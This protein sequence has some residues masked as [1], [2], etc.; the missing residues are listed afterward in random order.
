MFNQ[1]RTKEGHCLPLYLGFS[2]PTSVCVDNYKSEV[3]YDPILQITEMDMRV[4][5][6]RSLKT[7]STTINHT[8]KPDPKNE[9]DDQR[10]VF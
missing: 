1:A 6:T 9:I 8:C 3:I 5:G 7:P 4:I 2:N 10:Q